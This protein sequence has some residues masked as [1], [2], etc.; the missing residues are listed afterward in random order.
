MNWPEVTGDAL[1]AAVDRHLAHLFDVYFQ[2]TDEGRLQRLMTGLQRTI[3]SY[4]AVMEKL[5]P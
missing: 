3:D 5:E 2:G 4:D 1:E